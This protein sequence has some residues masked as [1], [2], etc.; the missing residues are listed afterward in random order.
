MITFDTVRAN[1]VLGGYEVHEDMVPLNMLWL[2]CGRPPIRVIT[3][4]SP[5]TSDSHNGGVRLED[6]KGSLF[7]VSTNWEGYYCKWGMPVGTVSRREL[8]D[9][10]VKTH[11]AMTDVFVREKKP[12]RPFFRLNPEQ[13]TY[14]T[15]PTVVPDL[16]SRS[17]LRAPV[18]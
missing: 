3:S 4:R 9:A 16:L 12:L 2:L 7:Y 5:L 8:Y 1:A 11:D 15:T 13:T 14:W 10:A 18:L 17:S 6:S